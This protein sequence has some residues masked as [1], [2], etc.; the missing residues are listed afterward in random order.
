MKK[1]TII[2]AAVML[3]GISAAQAQAV[4]DKIDNASNKVDRAGST[5]DKTKS[6]GDKILGFF[7]EEKR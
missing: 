1:I 5:A 2:C 6:T 7:G 3:F 4:L